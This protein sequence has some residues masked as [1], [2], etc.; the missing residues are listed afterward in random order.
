MKRK[1]LSLTFVLTAFCSA[2]PQTPKW[3]KKIRM[4][5]VTIVA[6]D[7]KGELHETQGAF[8]NEEGDLITEYDALKGAVKATAIDQKGIE[9]PISYVKGASSM[10]NVARLST[11]LPEKYKIASLTMGK[12]A[13]SGQLVWI[14]PNAK[15]EKKAPCVVDTVT[16]A[17]AF[18]DSF[19]YYTLSTV[20]GERMSTSPV[21]N[22]EGEL[23]GLLQMPV[24][25]DTRSYVIDANFIVNLSIG[26]M[27]AA[28][29]DLNSIGIPKCLPDN[30]A[31]ASSFLYL[32]GAR[33][34]TG[35]LSYVDDFI[36]RFP[37]ST[38]G[39]TLKAEELVRRQQYAEADEVYQ[40]GL[41]QEGTKKDELHFSLSKAIYSL[42]QK[43]DYKVYADWTLER[44]S[45]E[46]RKAFEINPLPFYTSQLGECLY[47]EKKYDEACQQFLSLTKTNLRSPENFLFA[48]QCKQMVE[49]S[50]E[51]ILALQDSAIAFYPKPFPKEAAT[52]IILR[53]G[54]KARMGKA[55][56]AVQD[57]N[58]Y[59][60]LM[61]GQVGASFY[62]E[63]EQQ[64]I[65]C[66][67]YPAAL[68][69]IERAIR[70]Q[71]Q[72][73]LFWAESAA[74]N[75]RVGQIDEAIEAA[76]KA[77]SLDPQFPDPLRILGVCYA[78]KGDR[79]KARTYLQK[80]VELGDTLAQGVLDK[81]AGK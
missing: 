32:L 17:T 4:A 57:F 44:A 36:K 9:I 13:K 77:V 23:I 18:R 71:P 74:L 46:A 62:Y 26:A 16:E 27:D 81:L 22:E 30:E 14:M 37:E 47:A 79:N 55:R 20:P 2:M 56:E 19:T 45:A 58:E 59:E 73:A 35:Y 54:T 6:S 41:Q 5:Q 21:M 31:A 8:V 50:D 10:Y 64:E 52:A 34:T 40:K 39:Y 38:T 51:E 43:P 3:A 29:N 24:G 65:K 11:S 48:A 66:R 28:N 69:D 33:D 25:K 7:A 67:M 15:A 70:L 53:A 68:N 61:G 72:E 78:D 63:R 49:A 42:S 80:A 1:I 76:G 60:H 75:Y 12:P